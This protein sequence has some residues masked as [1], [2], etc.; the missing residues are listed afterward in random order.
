MR[1]THCKYSVLSEPFL[2]F[3]KHRL[4]C[5][6]I[7]YAHFVA[8]SSAKHNLCLAVQMV[9]IHGIE[10]R[11]DDKIQKPDY[12]IEFRVILPLNAFDIIL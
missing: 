5:I 2:M 6:C 3:N 10:T 9:N 11:Y 8:S 7:L 1:L 12:E 4:S